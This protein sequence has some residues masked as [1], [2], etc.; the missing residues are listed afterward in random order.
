MGRPQLRGAARVA[1]VDAGGSAWTAVALASWRACASVRSRARASFLR[2]LAGI[3]LRSRSRG[4]ALLHFPLLAF[5]FRLPPFRL[6]PLLLQACPLFL[7]EARAFDLLFLLLA[8]A[9]LPLP[10]FRFFARLLLGFPTGM[11]FGLAPRDFLGL[12]L[13]LF[14]LTPS[15]FLGA[16]GL[17]FLAPGV[18]PVA[19]GLASGCLLQFALEPLDLLPSQSI[20]LLAR[21]GFLVA[22]RPF[23]RL[24]FLAAAL[25]FFSLPARLLFRLRAGL[26]LGLLLCPLLGFAPH[27]LQLAVLGFARQPF[28]LLASFAFLQQA[29]L[30]LGFQPFALFAAPV[31]IAAQPFLGSPL[32]AL[33]GFARR[34]FG[35]FFCP[36]LRFFA[37]TAFFLQFAEQLFRLRAGALLG[38]LLYALL[39]PLLYALLDF[40]GEMLGVF[41]RLA[42][43]FLQSPSQIF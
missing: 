27:A 14:S 7:F 38:P 35:F 19:L 39:G 3:D 21:S 5:P 11:L 32:R 20:G 1:R 22:R 33:L 15:A 13:G 34:A 12:P 9:L 23:L 30:Q 31:F 41:C 28:G 17:F 43:G 24:A 16:R 25:P 4:G 37:R 18:F 29:S 10:R 8:L 2:S 40:T 6:P 42:L 36:A 26:L